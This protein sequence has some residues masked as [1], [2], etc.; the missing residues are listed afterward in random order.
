VV[1]GYHWCVADGNAALTYSLDDQLEAVK[2]VSPDSLLAE[3]DT[4]IRE[5]NQARAAALVQKYG[6]LNLPDARFQHAP[7]IRH[8]RRRRAPRGEVYRTVSESSPERGRPTV[9]P[10]CWLARVTASEYGKRADGYEEACK[11]LR[12]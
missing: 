2:R 1:A 8:Q 5:Q 4:A 11:L 10:A 12:V 3:A 9:G 6:E 7:E